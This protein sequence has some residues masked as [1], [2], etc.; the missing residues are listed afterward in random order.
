VPRSASGALHRAGGRLRVPAYLGAIALLTLFATAVLLANVRGEGLDAGA[1]VGLCLILVLATSHM[2]S[3]MANWAATMLMAPRRLPRMDFSA[4]ISPP[5]RTLV[6]VPA[7]LTAA[8]EIEDLA[9][10]LEVRFLANRDEHLHFGLL[11]D[12]RDAPHEAMAEDEALVAVPAKPSS[13]STRS[14]ARPMRS[15]SS[16]ARAAGIPPR[17]AGWAKRGSAASSPT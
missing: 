9:D 13:A 10:A 3:G 11:T 12:F 14:T 16:T 1:L 15:S 17:E 8:D 5:A 2:A 6:I 4:G 7:L